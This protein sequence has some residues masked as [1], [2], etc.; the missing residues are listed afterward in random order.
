VT[1]PL[2]ERGL[3]P[4]LRE[5]YEPGE[6]LGRRG[7]CE[8]FRAMRKRDHAAVILKIWW[9]SDQDGNLDADG[10]SEAA[11]LGSLS[12]PH[13]CEINDYQSQ[14]GVSW[15]EIP[16]YG[17]DAGIF[18]TQHGPLTLRVALDVARQLA[19]AVHAVHARD[20]VHRDICP[21]N[22]VLSA[23]ATHCYLID[24]GSTGPDSHFEG[25]ADEEHEGEARGATLDFCAPERCR[26]GLRQSEKPADLYGVGATLFYLISGH[27]PF[28]SHDD[29]ELVYAHLAVPPPSLGEHLGPAESLAD[30]V[31]QTLLAKSPGDRYRCPLALARDFEKI[32]RFIDRGETAP[33]PQLEPQA[34]YGTL[35]F[36]QDLEAAEVD[37]K[38]EAI[39]D[40]VL[41]G[42]ARIITHCS[43]GCTRRG[44]WCERLLREI[45][46]VGARCVHIV[47]PAFGEAGP[48]GTVVS[49]I[50]KV[51]HLTVSDNPAACVALA[52]RLR[53][54]LGSRLGLAVNLV[55][56]I[57][58]IVSQWPQVPIVPE[59]EAESRTLKTLADVLY[60]LARTGLPLCL[61]VGDAQ[62]LDRGSLQAFLSLAH[63]LVEEAAPLLIVFSATLPDATKSDAAALDILAQLNQG[64]GDLAFHLAPTSVNLHAIVQEVAATFG[65]DPQDQ[66]LEA[67]AEIATQRSRASGESV[68]NWLRRAANQGAIWF[69]IDSSHPAY[70]TWKFNLDACDHVG[71]TED[72]VDLA[73]AHFEAAPPTIRTIIEKAACLGNAISSIDLIEILDD[74]RRFVGDA[75]AFGSKYNILQSAPIAVDDSGYLTTSP[76]QSHNY[77]F[78]FTSDQLRESIVARIAPEERQ[79]NFVKIGHWI[80]DS[81]RADRSDPTR[82]YRAT[83][84]FNLIPIEQLSA[85]DR[86]FYA[87]CNLEAGD[88]ARASRAHTEAADFFARGLTLIE[89]LIDEKNA[90]LALSLHEEACAMA[91]LCGELER[92]HDLAIAAVD[93]TQDT[94]RIAEL[95][96]LALISQTQ[97]G[98]YDEAIAIA[99]RLMPKLG[100][101]IGSSPWESARDAAMARVDAAL[102]ITPI[103]A[104]AYSPEMKDKRAR[105]A[106]R[107]LIHLTSIGRFSQRNLFYLAIALQVDLSLRYGHS[108]E[109]P[110]AFALFALTQ[111][112]ES[113]IERAQVFANAALEGATIFAGPVEESQT[114]FVLA[115]RVFG[116][117]RPFA[118]TR[119]F[120]IRGRRLGIEHGD[121]QHAGY[122]W[123]SELYTSIIVGDSLKSIEPE[124]AH[125]YAFAKSTGHQIAIDTITGVAL[126]AAWM[127]DVEQEEP[128]CAWCRESDYVGA[129]PGAAGGFAGAHYK[130]L[131]AMGYHVQGEPRVAWD[132]LESAEPSLPL[133]DAT[134]ATPLFYFYRGLSASELLRYD[135]DHPGRQGL[136]SEFL[137]EQLA[138]SLAYFEHISQWC[139]SNFEHY[140]LILRAERSSHLVGTAAALGAYEL[141][142]G[143]L[144]GREDFRHNRALA[145]ECYAHHLTRQ[146]WHEL[147]RA[148][149]NLAADDYAA[150]GWQR[151]SRVLSPRP[152]TRRRFGTDQGTPRGRTHSRRDSD[153]GFVTADLRPIFRA[154]QALSGTMV[155]DEVDSIFVRNAVET[156]GTTFGE[157]FLFD[158][159]GRSATHR[160]VASYGE[161]DG[162]RQQHAPPMLVNFVL[163][164]GR[165]LMIQDA[166]SE[167]RFGLSAT[168][169]A[170]VFCMPIRIGP[171]VRAVLYLEHQTMACVMRDEELEIL[172]TLATQAAICRHNAELYHSTLELNATLEKRVKLRTRA[173]EDAQAQLVATA[174]QAGMAELAADVLHN[175]GNLLNNLCVSTYALRGLHARLKVGRIERLCVAL[176]EARDDIP[177]FCASPKAPLLLEF[178]A[179]FLQM[180]AQDSVQMIEETTRLESTT[181]TMRDVIAAQQNLAAGSKLIENV[182]LRELIEEFIRLHTPGLKLDGIV[183][184]VEAPYALDV[185]A[186]RS[187][188]LHILINLIKNA[189]EALA[190]RQDIAP[191]I[192]ISLGYENGAPTLQ[193]AD[194]G[195]GFSEDTL[196]RIFAHGYTTK[197]TGKGFGLHS[198]ANYMT[199]MG[200]SIRAENL[201][202]GGALFVLTFAPALAIARAANG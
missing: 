131:R 79:S 198:C 46:Q 38:R 49:L 186:N 120:A 124:A 4:T 54:R 174:H 144:S 111:I 87:S 135:A 76:T 6:T 57:A 159:S 48:F 80:L 82:Y 18:V 58:R 137:H 199:E 181:S 81:R 163:K 109:S 14:F 197:A 55:E 171:E 5:L 41:G 191:T 97:R 183:L 13:I 89:G 93:L 125:A 7:N 160:R 166:R 107:A 33:A 56:S 85:N 9:H 177:A 37:E 74:E 151:K 136:E 105:L 154:T 176:K 185:V 99:S 128:T 43:D 172:R 2:R 20:W 167:S 201:P 71:Q 182:D 23:D 195:P 196:T 75:E 62:R 173:L 102:A 122:N 123:M 68:A 84:Y 145:R 115:N 152:Q 25:E 67:L 118:E 188:L 156:T 127:Q 184:H 113:R 110:H 165:E 29:D 155:P 42:Q 53:F 35:V 200:G 161:K 194:N 19:L 39:V 179:G 149:L 65:R 83:Q 129:R 153:R 190:Q 12:H 192:R 27:A 168:G 134:Y 178:V 150:L 26:I 162:S 15:L 36:H 116:W 96:V 138:G 70:G 142:L 141:A 94:L 3:S 52:S 73:L 50:A 61:F 1:N 130:I 8:V 91:I 101:E 98:H 158:F 143:S 40:A 170:A 164:S 104:Y 59:Q 34:Q 10:K 103:D 60:C 47:P 189:K 175:V 16:D 28:S 51:I 22:I 187:R 31:I 63:L 114:L 45:S 108:P 77:D 24:F 17:L 126:F 44:S 180:V 86:I 30:Q 133:I 11:I 92:A 21:N 66:E 112:S 193:I 147:A 157:L 64:A 121:F 78:C 148:Q 95:E 90:R 69:E 169:V 146:G 72:D 202:H 106:M 119:E 140:L 88:V 32:I 117:L 100:I 132:W 139:R